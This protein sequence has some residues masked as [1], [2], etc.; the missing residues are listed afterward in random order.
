MAEVEEAFYIF[1]AHRWED[2]RADDG[3]ANLAAVGVA[4]EHEVD[5]WEAGMLHDGVDEVRLVAEEDDGRVGVGRNGE[6]QVTG[7]RSGIAGAGEPD[8]GVPVLNGDVVVDQDRG[9][10]GFEGLDDLPGA[11]GDVVVAEDRV[12]LRGGEA[13]EDFGAE[14]GG[15]AGEGLVAGAAADE[16]AGDDDEV[17]LEGVDALDGFLEEVGLGVFLQVDVR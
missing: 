9:S 4:G 16:V 10:M 17:R 7:G 1:F 11:D 13:G 6:I 8:V 14:S 3:K 12:A 2:E 5:E 15:F